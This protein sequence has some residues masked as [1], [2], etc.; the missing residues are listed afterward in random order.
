MPRSDPEAVTNTKQEE[1]INSLLVMVS[2]CKRL[3]KW[4]MSARFTFIIFKF[5]IISPATILDLILL[6]SYDLLL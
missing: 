4:V 6:A 5:I 2:V 1:K 3:I